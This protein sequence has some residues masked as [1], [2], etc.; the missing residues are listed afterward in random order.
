MFIFFGDCKGVWG[1]K[2]SSLFGGEFDWLLLFC[3]IGKVFPEVV[4]LVRVSGYCEVYWLERELLFF[5][6]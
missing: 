5:A 6:F 1:L 4:G 3:N 2:S